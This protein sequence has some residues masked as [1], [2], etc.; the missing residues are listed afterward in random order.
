[1]QIPLFK[2]AGLPL[3]ALPF[4]AL[5]KGD[6]VVYRI[7]FTNDDG[8]LV[9]EFWYGMV[10]LCTK[11]GTWIKFLDMEDGSK[12]SE[13]KHITDPTDYYDSWMKVER[14]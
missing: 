9:E 1:M 4:M 13:E 5:K 8:V 12:I 14:V 11:Q 2:E 6:E 7:P 3:R 10:T